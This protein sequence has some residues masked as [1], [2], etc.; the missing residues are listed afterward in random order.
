[1]NNNIKGGGWLTGYLPAR[2]NNMRMMI[3][4]VVV[5]LIFVVI[6]GA[7]WAFDLHELFIKEKRANRIKALRTDARRAKAK[8]LRALQKL[9][10]WGKKL[11]PYIMCL[12]K[13]LLRLAGHLFRY[14][15][16]LLK[17]LFQKLNELMQREN[18][19]YYQVAPGLLLVFEENL[20]LAKALEGHPY[21]AP[22]I[23]D[24]RLDH[25]IAVSYLISAAG[26]APGYAEIGQEEFNCIVTQKIK[27]FFAEKRQVRAYVRIISATQNYLHFAVTYTPYGW[28]RL[29]QIYPPVEDSGQKTPP[30]ALDET[31]PDDDGA[32]ETDA[33]NGSNEP[34]F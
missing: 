13:W 8:L 34:W 29:Q 12:L 17:W 22:F 1:M 5:L 25:D 10:E 7:I 6:G 15:A 27:E 9:T 18:D 16:K 31:I 2:K 28:T 20:A 19:R 26:K 14:T 30:P 21:Q 4:I 33:E 3:I 24:C 23:E 11:S 32:A